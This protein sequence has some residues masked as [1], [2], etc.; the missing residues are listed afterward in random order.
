MVKADRRDW[1]QK[2][3]KHVHHGLSLQ[4]LS[5]FPQNKKIKNQSMF[6]QKIYKYTF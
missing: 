6:R 5:I 3:T 4:S 2:Y 1:C